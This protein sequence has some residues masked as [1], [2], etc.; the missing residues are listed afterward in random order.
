MMTSRKVDVQYDR[1]RSVSDDRSEPLHRTIRADTAIVSKSHAIRGAVAQMLLMA[2]TN[3]TVLLLGETGI[4]K[5]RFA[6]A[7]HDA[8][9]RRHRLMVRVNA[10]A[11]PASLIESE[12][13]GHERGAFTSALARQVGR[14]EAAQGSTL[15][16]DEIGELSPELQVKLLRVLEERTIERLGS[17]RSITLDVRII[18]ATNR[19]LDEAV[20]NGRFREDLF[21]RLNVFPI[22]I[23]PLRERREDI[24]DLAR[25]CI[26]GVAR[27]YRANVD[28]ITPETLND[29]E[30]YSWPGNIR[31]LRDVIERALTVATSPTLAPQVPLAW[32]VSF[33]GRTQRYSAHAV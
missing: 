32:S 3:S 20:R 31:D 13:F 23:A 5:E 10:A 16:L 15:F 27:P 21:Y 11:I 22:T 14:F 26:D 19:N 29:L 12:L 30:Q 8:S 4:G 17:G 25:T 24:P 1:D 9:P 28:S 18:A 6:Q 7:I 33:N 2:P